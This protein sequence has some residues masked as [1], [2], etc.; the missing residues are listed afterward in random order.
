MSSLSCT[1]LKIFSRRY[2]AFG[3]DGLP[4][5]SKLQQTIQG[6]EGTAASS[7]ERKEPHS[8][9]R[10][11]SDR[12]ARSGRARSAAFGARSGLILENSDNRFER[13]ERKDAEPAKKI[14]PALPIG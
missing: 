11:I 4:R 5:M 8:E 9:R 14:N 1:S 12:Q 13:G 3:I 10:N 6:C 2:N 7:P